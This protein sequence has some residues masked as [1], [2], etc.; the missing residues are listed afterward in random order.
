MEVVWKV[1]LV[2]LN[3]RFTASITFHNVL[4]GF[5]VGRCTGTPS[6]EDKL[7]HQ[8]VSMREE[9]VSAIFLDLH[10]SYIALDRDRCLEI[11]EGKQSGTLGPQHPSGVLGQA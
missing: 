1:V 6:L 11:L 4:H 7:I 5:R 9:V 10:K 2:I 8:L 3:E